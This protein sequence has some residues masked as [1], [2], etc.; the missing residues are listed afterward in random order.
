[1]QW[2]RLRRLYGLALPFGVPTAFAVGLSAVGRRAPLEA[3]GR[4]PL[5]GPSR[6]GAAGTHLPFPKFWL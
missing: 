3:I 1:M 5:T 4:R 6:Q 2:C